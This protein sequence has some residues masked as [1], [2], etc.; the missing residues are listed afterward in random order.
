[1]RELYIL[2]LE[3][4]YALT[5]ALDCGQRDILTDFLLHLFVTANWKKKFH[6]C[7]PPKQ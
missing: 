6:T 2:H 4:A 1:M 3:I 5:E 7:R